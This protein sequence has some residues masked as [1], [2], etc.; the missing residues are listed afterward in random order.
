[1]RMQAYQFISLPRL[2]SSGLVVYCWTRAGYQ[3]VSFKKVGGMTGLQRAIAK[4]KRKHP[5]AKDEPKRKRKPNKFRARRCRCLLGHVHDSGLEA[6]HCVV[7]HDMLK[8]KEIRAVERQV[9]FPLI[10][11]VSHYPDFLITH[12]DGSREVIE[13]KGLATQAWVVKMK[14]FKAIYPD[15]KY[16]VWRR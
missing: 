2:F 13:S 5:R 9:K 3:E 6:G 7:I 15:I 4:Y 16:T 1:M 11:G 10:G 8:H 14:T 12:L